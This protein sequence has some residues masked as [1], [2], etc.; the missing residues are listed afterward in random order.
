MNFTLP[1]KGGKFTMLLR[2]PLG[3]AQKLSND[4]ERS[5]LSHQTEQ[6]IFRNLVTFFARRKRRCPA[7]YGNA[8]TRRHRKSSDRS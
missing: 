7:P 2:K 6:T 1:I 3:F 5:N 8:K 4:T